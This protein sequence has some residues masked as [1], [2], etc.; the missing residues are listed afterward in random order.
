VFFENHDTQRFNEIFPSLSDY[1]LVLTLISTCRGIPQIYYGSEIGMA[2]KKEVG[3]ADIRQDFPGGWP[4]DNVTAFVAEDNKETTGFDRKVAG[5]TA[6]QE[7]YHAFTKKLLNWRKN[8]AVIHT[9][10]MIHF[11]PENNVYVYF[12]I[13][14]NKAVMVI[15]NNS[16]LEQNMNP[17][18]FSEGFLGLTSGTDIL[19]SETFDLNASNWTLKAKTSYVIELR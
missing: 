14:D 10:K 16:A 8:N 9:G 12:R 13:L 19:S 15:I 4:A 11:I 5:R 2:G 3:D 17:S 1:K 7:A 6:E 18:R